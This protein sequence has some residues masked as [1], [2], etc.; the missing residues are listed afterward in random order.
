MVVKHI[1]NGRGVCSESVWRRILPTLQQG[2]SAHWRADF[3]DCLSSPYLSNVLLTAV[4]RNKSIPIAR[5]VNI[6]F[7]SKSENGFSLALLLLPN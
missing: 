4:V 5:S 3:E 2:T 7:L 6:V 1:L